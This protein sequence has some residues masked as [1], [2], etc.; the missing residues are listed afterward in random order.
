MH[1]DKDS[2]EFLEE[3]RISG[4][5]NKYCKFLPIDIEFGT[6]QESIDDPKGKKDK[7]GNIEKI[8]H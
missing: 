1:I 8:I 4:I 5:L 2:K 6:K 3:N 7:D